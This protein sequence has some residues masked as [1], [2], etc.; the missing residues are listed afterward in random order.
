M[1][2]KADDLAEDLNIRLVERLHRIVL[3][4]K[5]YAGFLAEESLHCRRLTVNECHD[6]IAVV[7][8]RLLPH[9]HKISIKDANVNHAVSLDA[10][11]KYVL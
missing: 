11:H 2:I 4:L 10:Q 1:P 6:N 7:C 9:K 3:R 8:R 5:A